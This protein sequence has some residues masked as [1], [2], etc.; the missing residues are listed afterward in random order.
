M[1]PL[2]VALL[3]V[4]GALLGLAFMDGQRLT[5]HT[6]GAVVVVATLF[7]LTYG[8]LLALAPDAQPD[9]PG[10]LKVLLALLGAAAAAL[11]LHLFN[12]LTRKDVA[13]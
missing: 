7:G 2:T 11:L 4:P 9:M 8:L 3:V 5:R 6:F 12:L 13:Q 1:S 10:A